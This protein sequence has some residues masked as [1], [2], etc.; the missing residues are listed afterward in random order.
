MICF[1]LTRFRWDDAGREVKF[2]D[3]D[4]IRPDEEHL[5]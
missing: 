2:H 1:N 5:S 4:I 3:A